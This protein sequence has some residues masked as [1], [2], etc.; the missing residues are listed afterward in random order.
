MSELTEV[1]SWASGRVLPAFM[2]GLCHH[3][4]VRGHLSVASTRIAETTVP[5]ENHLTIEHLRNVNV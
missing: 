1:Q 4:I 5:K 3:C 2:P